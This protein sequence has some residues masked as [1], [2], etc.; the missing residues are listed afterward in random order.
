MPPL[1]LDEETAEMIET[2]AD[3][4]LAALEVVTSSS[5]IMSVL[6]GFGLQ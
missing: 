3:N 6:L 1:L 4:M 5:L 2:G